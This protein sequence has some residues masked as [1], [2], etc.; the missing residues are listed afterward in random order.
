MERENLEMDLRWAG[1]LY[2]G[3]R[4]NRIEEGRLGSEQR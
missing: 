3:K 4:A 1:L 2:G